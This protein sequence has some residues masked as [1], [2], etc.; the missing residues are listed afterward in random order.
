MFDYAVSSGNISLLINT[1][2]LTA[3]IVV[4]LDDLLLTARLTGAAQTARRERVLIS[5]QEAA[6]LEQ[7]LAPA[8]AAVPPRNGPPGWPSAGRSPDRKRSR[9]CCRPVQHTTRPPDPLSAIQNS[10]A[11]GQAS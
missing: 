3:A 2:E 11:D 10:D 1:L 5:A 9:C 7:H 4:G 6:M 8:R